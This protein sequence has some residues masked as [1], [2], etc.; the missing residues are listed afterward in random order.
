MILYSGYVNRKR[1]RR[2]KRDWR[3][4]N[5]NKK[6]ADKA[7]N[8]EESDWDTGRA[9]IVL[10]FFLLLCGSLMTN[11]D[12][13]FYSLPIYLKEWFE[14]QCETRLNQ[15]E[16]RLVC[17]SVRPSLIFLHLQRSSAYLLSLSCRLFYLSCN[18]QD[19]STTTTL[20]SQRLN[21]F[22]LFSSL[23]SSSSW[24]LSFSSSSSSSSLPSSPSSSLLFLFGARAC[25]SRLAFASSPDN[26]SFVFWHSLGS[27]L[28]MH[29]LNRMQWGW[30]AWVSGC[31]THTSEQW[32][33][34]FAFPR[35][36]SL[37][38]CVSLSAMIVFGCWSGLS[39]CRRNHYVTHRQHIFS[40]S[41]GCT[42][43]HW[44]E[45][46]SERARVQRCSHYVERLNGQV[47]KESLTIC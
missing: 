32:I 15:N 25:A 2:G 42:C 46:A 24:A 33:S 35:S 4:R 45:R 18:T 38:L 40:F 21:L 10:L 44:Q 43:F 39:T 41:P 27:S 37:S 22:C 29:A 36:L 19:Y 30:V 8:A 3:R 28:W 9:S 31:S 7:P 16:L 11:A 13:S 14:A 12:D 20:S 1:R 26:W 6:S 5:K 47:H 34:E 17:L 23:A